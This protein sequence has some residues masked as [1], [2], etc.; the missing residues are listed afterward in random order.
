MVKY[1]MPGILKKNVERGTLDFTTAVTND[2]HNAIINLKKR[3]N[4]N[5]HV[6]LSLK[7][8]LTD[9]DRART[10]WISS[11]TSDQII[12]QVRG[13]R[14]TMLGLTIDADG[15]NDGDFISWE[16]YDI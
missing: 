4:S 15:G 3:S 8:F 11:K 5:Y 7:N 6:Q 2:G 9:G 14:Q 1:D 13:L 12:A 16:V 10:V